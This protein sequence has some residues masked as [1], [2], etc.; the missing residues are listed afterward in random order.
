MSPPVQTLQ[1]KCHCQKNKKRLRA[2]R[3]FQL[4]GTALLRII[5]RRH[6][7]IGRCLSPEYH[8]PNVPHAFLSSKSMR[9]SFLQN[10]GAAFKRQNAE[11]GD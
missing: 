3:E 5:L 8:F 9:S 7:S 6:L 1:R 4:I 11:Q 2:W 10:A